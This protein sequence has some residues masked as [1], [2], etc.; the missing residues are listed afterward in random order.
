LNSK[1]GSELHLLRILGRHRAYFDAKLLAVTGAD[2][3]EWLDFPSGE[4]RRPSGEMRR[5]ISENVL[6]DREW[7][8]LNFLPPGDSGASAWKGA[9]PTHRPGPNWDAIGRLRFGGT[10]EWLLVEA[11][12]NFQELLS[13]CQAADPASV[14]RISQTLNATKLALGVAQTCD[15]TRPY[16]QFCNRLAALQVLNRAGSAARLLYVYFCGDVGDQRRTCPA[17]EEGWRSE[18]GRQDRHV[19]LT[20][21]PLL[22]RIHKLFIDVQCRV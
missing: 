6:W 12:A 5:D 15:W 4:M 9:W 14:Q 7:Q 1:F 13:D 3:I 18:L 8:Q 2:H 21:H 16:Y 19:G 11:K 22:D 10:Q 17:N 20:N